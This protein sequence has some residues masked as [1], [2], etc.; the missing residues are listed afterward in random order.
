MWII[1]GYVAM[2]SKVPLTPDYVFFVISLMGLG[3]SSWWVIKA[4]RQFKK[5]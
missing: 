2:F 5:V 1:P 4:A 3:F